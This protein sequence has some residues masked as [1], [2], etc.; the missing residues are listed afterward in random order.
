M[1]LESV[2]KG[3]VSMSQVVHV[4]SNANN[5]TNAGVFYVNSNNALTVSSNVN[6]IYSNPKGR[7]IMAGRKPTHGMTK[8]RQYNIWRGMKLR[9]NRPDSRLKRWYENINYDPR[10]ESFDAFWEDMKEGYADHLTLDRIDSQKDYSK[11]NCRWITMKQQSRNRRDNI[12]LEHN[13]Q[14]LCVTD[15]AKAVGLPRSLIYSR[16]KNNCPIEKLTEPSRK[17]SYYQ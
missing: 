14:K 15:F 5:G 12:Y 10:W 1:F 11:E 7:N 6:M 16:I 2:G 4:G 17:R 8:T 13:G 9:C 3:F